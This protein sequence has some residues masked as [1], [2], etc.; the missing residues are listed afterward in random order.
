MYFYLPHINDPMYIQQVRAV[1][2][3]AIENVVGICKQVTILILL[4]SYFQIGNPS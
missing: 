4:L 1:I 3:P 2:L